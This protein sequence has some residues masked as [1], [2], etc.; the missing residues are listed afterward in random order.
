MTMEAPRCFRRSFKSHEA[1]SLK[2]RQTRKRQWYPVLQCYEACIL[3]VPK[4]KSPLTFRSTTP[5]A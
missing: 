4:G 2:L 5:L 1:A 3:L